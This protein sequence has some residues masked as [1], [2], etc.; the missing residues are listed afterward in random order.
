L[1]YALNSALPLFLPHIG[2]FIERGKSRT[3]I[4]YFS[5]FDSLDLIYK[6]FISFSKNSEYIDEI[7]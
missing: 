1:T 5:H 2:A 3:N 4:K 6:K 7:F